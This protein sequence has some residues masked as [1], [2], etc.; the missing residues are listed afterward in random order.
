[1]KPAKFDE[2]E[3]QRLVTSVLPRVIHF[4][5]ENQRYTTILEELLAKRERTAEEKRMIELLTLLIED[6]EEKHY[7][8]PVAG[9]LEILRHLMDANGLRQADL[10]DVF[11]S[12]SIVSEVLHGKR[13]LAKSHIERL[14]RRFHVSPSLFFESSRRVA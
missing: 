12:P 4:E 14:S 11:G 9:P 2:R 10:V 8:L 6:F 5:E 13:D 3:Y 1:M 7:S